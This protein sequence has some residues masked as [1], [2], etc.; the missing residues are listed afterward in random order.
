M[1]PKHQTRIS[2]ASRRGFTVVEVM[3]A[4]SI[5]VISVL[6]TVS[7]FSYARRT[8][9]R[10]ENRLAC[11]H[12]AREVMETLRET[13]YESPD[14]ELLTVGAKKTLPGYSKDR[15]Y[16][17]IV[18]TVTVDEGAI[19]EITVVVEWIEPTGTKT[20]TVSLTTLH[21]KGLHRK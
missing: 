16:Y 6:A 1:T 15:G 10:T 4:S 18:E 7:A 8:V 11:L 20:H 14:S 12:I 13:Q 17:D 2:K 19:K 9:S 3:V 21:S 5:L